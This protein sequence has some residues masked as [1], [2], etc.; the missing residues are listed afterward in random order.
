MKDNIDKCDQELLTEAYSGMI[1]ENKEAGD[2]PDERYPLLAVQ[3]DNVFSKIYNKYM[4][5]AMDEISDPQEQH[6]AA[7]EWAREEINQLISNYKDRSIAKG[8]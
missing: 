7:L 3:F 4:R 8:L 6:P 2:Y 5:T 1:S